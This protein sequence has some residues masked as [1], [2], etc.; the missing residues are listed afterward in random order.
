M[1]RFSRGKGY[2]ETTNN[3]QPD[4]FGD[5]LTERDAICSSLEFAD[6]GCVHL[7][8]GILNKLAFLI[9]E[10]GKH[11]GVTVQGIGRDKLGRITYRTLTLKL[12]RS[13]GLVATANG[14]VESCNDLATAGVA[15]INQA[16]CS[17]LQGSVNAVGLASGS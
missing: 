14:M 5:V 16:N 4:H 13:S 2:D 10:G 6:S 9:A 7:N 12:N 17:A 11:R 15:M 1:G 8:S 3:G